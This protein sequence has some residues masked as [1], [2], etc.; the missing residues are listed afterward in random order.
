MSQVSEWFQEHGPRVWRTL[1]R[2]GVPASDLEDALQETFVV[3]HRRSADY[4]PARAAPTTWLLG[5]AYRVAADFRRKSKH[6]R[7]SDREEDDRI[8]PAAGP[9]GALAQKQQATLLVEA[10]EALG[11]EKRAAFVLYEIEELECPEVAQI[12]SVPLGTIHSR[13]HQ[14]RADLEKF[15]RRAEA[16]DDAKVRRR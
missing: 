16:L 6:Y 10:L 12:L 15:L 5:I 8:D 7:A 14:A 1:A 13:L 4:D 11:D 2:F 9:E 3:A